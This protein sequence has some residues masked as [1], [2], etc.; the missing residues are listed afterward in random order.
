M[1]DD[2]AGQAYLLI[3]V[4]HVLTHAAYVANVEGVARLVALTEASTTS[5]AGGGL[6]E[7]VRRA[8]ANLEL[9]VGRRLLDAAGEIRRPS[10]A[11]GHGVD[12]VALTT[13]LVP[14]LR[15]VLA[16]LTRDLSLASAA[17]AATTPYVTLVRTICLE[18]SV[19]RWES[20]DLEVLVEHPPDVVVLVGGVDGGPVAPIRDMGEMLSAAYSV[21]PE[22][23]RPV[24][25]FAG[26]E[27]A[28]RS[29]I[30][31]L[32]GVIELRLVPNVRPA[33]HTENLAELR[34]ALAR[35]FQRQGIGGSEDLRL[36]GQWAGANVMYDLDAMART[37]RFMTR[38]H[39]L[40]KGVLGV[41]L[42]GSG[43]RVLLVRPE[44]VALT[45][46]SPCG[47]GAG[48]AALR[49]L[50][51]PTAVVRWMHHPLS[52]AE[53]WDRLSNVEVRPTGVPQTDEDWDLQQ[54]SA[55]EA[56][57]RTWIGAR[58]AWAS[59]PGDGQATGSADVILARGTAL[60][61][62]QTPGQA[63]L[64]LLDALEPAGLLRLA[65]DWANLLPGLS[66][67]AQANARAA[68]EVLDNDGLLEL[69][70]LVAPSG[71]LKAGTEALKV[72]MLVQGETRADVTVP[73]GTIRR[74]PL[75]VNER[76]RLELYPAR[77]L[78]LE[79]GRRG[80]GVVAEV[81]GGTLGVII[82][83]RGRPLRLPDEE[84]ERCQALEAWQR[85]IDE[86]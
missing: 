27:R 81:R 24:V 83:T 79:V 5:R 76:A 77:G 18:M 12:G 48:L 65:L 80:H 3:D 68:V 19:R 4:G 9:V 6:L 57:S 84:T 20:E 2:N 58:A 74:L 75:G 62:A 16:G 86:G 40:S 33:V 54:A 17:R 32:S 85:E 78:H 39:G 35:L 66:A 37:L 10:D 44:G 28:H 41:D 8:T 82:D 47:T 38:R 15:V 51:D 71:S 43:T 31:A 67:L 52:W 45:W 34:A 11:D 22:G 69:G 63:A 59:Y 29:L 60:N 26:N 21:L 53:V 72:R 46:A 30:A 25:I 73:A 36:L 50:G 23:M 13:S 70:T 1:T 61:H 49:A 64:V 56:L 7:G 42:G 14:S 55:R